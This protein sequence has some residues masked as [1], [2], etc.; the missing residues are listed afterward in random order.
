MFFLHFPTIF[1]RDQSKGQKQRRNKSSLS[2]FSVSFATFVL[3]TFYIFLRTDKPECNIKQS[4][5]DGAIL[6][7]CESSANP[8]D[9]TFA[10]FRGNESLVDAEV[11]NVGLVSVLTPEASAE[12]FGTYYCY[13]NNSV[14]A[15]EPCEIDLQG[16]QEKFRACLLF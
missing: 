14:G 16:T 11:N 4:E 8:E 10:W 12:N 13:V 2:I 9:V 15:G 5:D 3:Q 1:E 7:T 6:L